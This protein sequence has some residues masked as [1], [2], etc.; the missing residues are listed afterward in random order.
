MRALAPSY[1]QCNGSNVWNCCYVHCWKAVTDRRGDESVKTNARLAISCN[2]G[3]ELIHI[4]SP[5]ES[6]KHISDALKKQF[7]DVSAV[8][9]MALSSSQAISFTMQSEE[10][11][12]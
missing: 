4:V 11:L 3:D 10:S 2:V 8:G 6:P 7:S 5:S 1:E 9:K 12:E